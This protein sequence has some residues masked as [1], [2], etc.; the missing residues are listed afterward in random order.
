GEPA[1]QRRWRLNSKSSCSYTLV[2]HLIS[3]PKYSAWVQNILGKYNVA[4]LAVRDSVELVGDPINLKMNWY[5]KVLAHRPY[6]V[7]ATVAIVSGICLIVPLLT[8]KVPTFTDPTLGFETRGT[9][10]SQR[11]TAWQNIVEATRP[12]G[13]LTS[14]PGELLFKSLSTESSLLKHTANAST[15]S[16]D[17]L[18]YTPLKKNKKKKKIILVTPPSTPLLSEQNYDWDQQRNWTFGI[19]VSEA[20]PDYG[21]SSEPWKILRDELSEKRLNYDHDDHE[22]DHLSKDGFFCGAPSPVYSHMVLSTT[23][24][25]DFLSLAALRSACSLDDRL[26]SRPHFSS[27]CQY[28]TGNSCCHSWALHNYIAVLHDHKNC[29]QI[30]EHDV[31]ETRKLLVECA[32]YYHNLKLPS[33][34]QEDKFSSSAACLVVPP[35]CTKNN[36]VFNILHYLVD[37]N[38]LPHDNPRQVFVKHSM[39]FLPIARSSAVLPYYNTL[40]SKS[41]KFGNVKVAAMDLGLKEVLFDE[42][43][44]WDTWLILLGALFVF[45][46]MWIYT[47]SFLVTFMTIIAIGLSLGMS[48]FFYTIVFDLQFFPFMNLLAC[49]VSVGIGADDA[50]IYCKIWNCIKSEKPSASL[51]QVVQETLNHALL[52]MFIT[53]FTTAVAFLTSFLSSIT[54]IRCFSIF[55]GMAVVANLFLMVTWLPATVIISEKFSC[56]SASWLSSKTHFLDL[57][58]Y[59]HSFSSCFDHVFVNAVIRCPFV[60]V[61]ILGLFA[62]GSGISVLYYPGLQLPK[63]PDFQL[64][65]QSHQ[66]EQY[67]TFFKEKFWFERLERNSASNVK[68]PLRFVWGVKPIDSGDYFNPYSKGKLH[69][70]PSFDMTSPASQLWLKQFCAKIRKQPFYSSTLGPLLPNCFIES[71][72]SWMTRRCK[73][74]IDNIDRSPCC[75]VATIPYSRSVF[76]NCTVQVMA[77]L[78]RTPNLYEPGFAGP[79]FSKNISH[80]KIRAVIVE[81]DSNSSY[82]ISY[83]EA[84]IFFHK[85]E[86]WMQNE[87]ISAPPGL[88]HGWFVSDLHFYDLQDTI[89]ESTVSALTISMIMSLVVL[90]LV[91][92]DIL[93]SF[94][95]VLS[96]TSTIFVTLSILLLSGWELNVLESVAISSSIGLAVDFSLHYGVSYRLAPNNTSREEAVKYALHRMCGPTAMGALTTGFAGVFMLPSSVLAYNQIGMFLVIVMGVSWTYATFFLMSLLCIA[97]PRHGF[98]QFSYQSFMCCLCQK[99]G[100]VHKPPNNST[101]TNKSTFGNCNYSESTFSASSTTYP[102]HTSESEGHELDAFSHGNRPSQSRRRSGSLYATRTSNKA[103]S[104]QSPSATS[105]CTV[106]LCD[107]VDLS[108]HHM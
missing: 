19:N 78:Y 13:S 16:P 36:A 68:L 56:P 20:Q 93:V 57:R 108:R 29:F 3:A 6:I 54:A 31:E 100:N 70:D 97:G 98:G 53:S 42:S 67:D 14:N 15:S 40:D 88:Q 89:A 9:T 69:F 85:V 48:Y 43:L 107:D 21:N 7:L 10:I 76:K 39:M 96:V 61:F 74:T 92:L 18:S 23:D 2:S 44:V 51:Q 60:W 8:R 106:I 52:S 45:L 25:S 22:H 104:D 50:F 30:K 72:E 55:A 77:S 64:F 41:L 101:R 102:L 28:S 66:F 71:L 34:C 49:V 62:V 37:I 79:K 4:Q 86:S 1:A 81:Y 94:F 27:N 65:R 91:T 58:A 35:N 26:R 95:A 105:A 32:P 84:N 87:L 24:G 5:S 63:S 90:F 47:E 33:D 82:M 73:D 103:T 11:I 38:F 75:E 59:L 83:E 46:C 80:P 99:G 17:D 12:S